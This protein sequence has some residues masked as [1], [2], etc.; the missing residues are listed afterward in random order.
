M[1]S[2]EFAMISEPYLTRKPLEQ[3]EPESLIQW[4]SFAH[5]LQTLAETKAP[6]QG[7]LERLAVVEKREK[8]TQQLRDEYGVTEPE[9]K[10][11]FQY[12]KSRVEMYSKRGLTDGFR[13]MDKDHKGS[14]SGDEIKEF[15]AEGGLP[16]YVNDNTLGVLVDW[17]DLN[18]D[19]EIDYLELSSVLLCGARRL[20]S[21]PSTPPPLPSPPAP[22]AP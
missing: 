8:A 13:R 17:A 16:W 2:E 10:L 19:D 21:Q 7:F 18:G 11:A 4:R 6:T 9:L 5:D 12:F 14:L 15:F 1:T 22:P 20:S 3:G